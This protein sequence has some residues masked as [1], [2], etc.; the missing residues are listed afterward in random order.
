M[1]VGLRCWWPLRFCWLGGLLLL[2]FSAWGQVPAETPSEDQSVTAALALTEYLQALDA[3]IHGL[4]SNDVTGAQQQADALRGRSFQVRGE[5]YEVDASLLDTVRQAQGKASTRAAVQRL[6][7]TRDELAST[8][9]SHPASVDDDLL[10]QIDEEQMVERMRARGELDDVEVPSTLLDNALTRWLG[11]VLEGMAEKL[12]D[13]LRW[14]LKYWRADMERERAQAS[15]DA[16]WVTAGV[17][18]LVALIA[19]LALRWLRS[20]PV[21][22]D[23]GRLQ[24]GQSMVPGAGDDN[25]LS[26]EGEEWQRY[27]EELAAAGRLREAIRAWY[28]AVLVACYRGGLLHYRKGRTNWEYIAALSPSLPWRSRFIS[29]TRRFELEWYG[30]GASGEDALAACRRDATDILGRLSGDAS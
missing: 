24:S 4:R 12:E 29:L 20:N 1:K 8:L 3:M 7:V 25:P 19:W 27:A 21:P 6:Q 22:A 26:R 14:L 30:H 9:P 16:R 28:H 23:A 15:L 5:T 17:V 13:L 10:R 11:E 2:A 18:L